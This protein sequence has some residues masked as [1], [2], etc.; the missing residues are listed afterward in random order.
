MPVKLHEEAGGR[1]VILN[2]SGKI[3]TEDYEHFIPEV[4]R[5]VKVHGKAR[6]LV[7]MHDFHGWSLGAVW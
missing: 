1:I 5:A 4:E 2:L 3:A 7:R 6:L